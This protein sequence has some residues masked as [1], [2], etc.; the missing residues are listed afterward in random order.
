MKKFNIVFLAIVLA[1]VLAGVAQEHP[2]KPASGDT[3]SQAPPEKPREAQS[4]QTPGQ[5]LAHASN[6]AATGNEAAEGEE[7]AAFKHSPVVRWMASK[8]GISIQAEYWVLYSIDFAIIALAIGWVWKKNIPAAFRA[9]TTSIRKTMDEAQAAS[10]EANR[11]LGDIEGRLAKLDQ[12]IANMRS[13]AEAEA[14]AEEARI[15]AAA[16][17]DSRKIVASAQAEIESATRGAQRDLKAYAAELAVS[18]AEKKIQVDPSTDRQLVQKF[19]RELGA[20]ESRGG[21]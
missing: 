1:F 14:A 4:P 8:L 10:A 12:E 7:T 6:E 16:E 13:S 21:R 20:G 19:S 5:Q 17:E 15:R 9:R 2:A 3:V 18:L 11:R